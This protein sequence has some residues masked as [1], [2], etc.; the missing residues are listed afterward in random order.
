M[1]DLLI[2]IPSE[3]MVNAIAFFAKDISDVSDGN[4]ALSWF[5]MNVP[6]RVV[7]EQSDFMVLMPFTR[8]LILPLVQDTTHVFLRGIVSHLINFMKA[9]SELRTQNAN[10]PDKDKHK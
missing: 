8:L 2:G 3:S 10:L 6:R 1:V 5:S 4:R 7:S 9:S